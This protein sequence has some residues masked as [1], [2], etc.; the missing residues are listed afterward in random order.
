MCSSLTTHIV[1]LV[2]KKFFTPSMFYLQQNSNNNNV[3]ARTPKKNCDDKKKKEEN[4]AN[5][6]KLFVGFP[7]GLVERLPK[8]MTSTW[9]DR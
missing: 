7:M 6:N 4:V 5:L 9:T 3:H 1:G 8:P 2:P